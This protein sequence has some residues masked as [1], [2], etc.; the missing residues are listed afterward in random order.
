MAAFSQ[1]EWVDPNK[2]KDDDIP[3]YA[4]RCYER[5]LSATQEQREREKESLGF[6]I[7]GKHQWLPD[8]IESREGTQRPWITINRCKPAVDQT[9]NESRNNPPGPKATPVGAGADDAGAD[10][11]EGLIREYEFRS[12]AQDEAYPKSLFYA[13]AGGSGAF[14]LSTEFVSERSLEQ[15]LV[16]KA[17]ADPSRIFYDPDALRACREDAMWQGEISVLSEQALQEEFPDVKLRV[18]NR[19]FVDKA[20]SGLG[21]LQS[22]MSWPGDAATVNKWTTNGRG[23]YW[24]CKFW[25]VTFSFE[26]LRLYSDGVLR[27]DGEKIPKGA[28]ERADIE[29]R[30]VPRRKV[31]KHVV[32]A[33]DHISKTEWLG[34]HIPIYWVMGPEIWR[35]G[36]LYRLSLIEP[37]RHPQR[38]LNYAASSAA[39]FVGQ[40]SKFRWLGWEGQFDVTNAQGFNP[41]ESSRTFWAYAELKPAW[42]INPTT[43]E[44][45]LLP[46]PQ[47]NGW[48]APIQRLLEFMTAMGEAIK[49]ATS[50]FFD[51]S[52]Q[53]VA[54]VQSGKAIE[55]LQQQTN[56][57]TVNWQKALHLAITLSYR[58]ADIIM[59]KIYD[60]PRVRA[61]V[62]PG[63]KSEITEI[64]REFPPET[65]DAATGKYRD[66]NGKLRSANSLSTGQ[67]AWRVEAGPG[68]EEDTDEAIQDLVEIAKLNPQ[69]FAQ[70]GP[71]SQFIRLVGRGNPLVNEFADAIQP[72]PNQDA[73]PAQ[74]EQQLQGLQAQNQKLMGLIQQMQREIAA[75]LPAVEAQKFKAILDSITK[76]QVERI[77]HGEGDKERAHD[78]VQHLTGQA[79]ELAMQRD[80]QA[81]AQQLAAIEPQNGVESQQ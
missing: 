39:E 11:R 47:P 33:L 10:I 77:K 60:G 26:T 74:L 27:F 54:D 20:R 22:A 18:L 35:D 17:I 1:S 75:K 7:G 42:A 53:N 8:E 59:Q 44:A 67:Y 64:N 72:V 80:A 49:A 55:A 32:T 25:R 6:Y 62:R 14:E 79:H 43:Q 2:I 66:K 31:W 46:P 16:V 51:P 57:G 15:Q 78:M 81:G 65:L 19:S 12:H 3:Q 45:T 13:A 23:P 61:I 29:P 28:R 58:D 63:N 37:A 4:R 70:P 34:P 5:Y 24:V 41:W 50:V 69:V 71:L 68:F 52:Q 56:M 73:S 48:E 30:T 9:V 21:W 36:K 40:M 38:A 76:I